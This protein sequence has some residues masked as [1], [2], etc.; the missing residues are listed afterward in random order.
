M[1]VNV[2]KVKKEIETLS[3]PLTSTDAQ[4][5]FYEIVFKKKVEEGLNEADEGMVSDW[6]DFKKEVRSWYNSK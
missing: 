1:T 4:N 2:I 3:A 5:I 6:D